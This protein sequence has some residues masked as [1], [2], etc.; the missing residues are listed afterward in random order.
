M[1]NAAF[2][3]EWH[4]LDLKEQK[5]FL[6]LLTQLQT[7]IGKHAYR[8]VELNLETL[9]KVYIYICVERQRENSI[10]LFILGLLLRH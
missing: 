7:E 9:G 5:I 2:N 4:R 3:S 8:L 10:I 6:T 1:A